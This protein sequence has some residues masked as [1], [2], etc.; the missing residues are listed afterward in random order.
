MARFATGSATLSARTRI[1]LQLSLL[2]DAAEDMAMNKANGLGGAA[3][4]LRSTAAHFV[5]HV[6]FRG[7]RMAACAPQGPL[8]DG[9]QIPQD[10]L[11]TAQRLPN[12]PETSGDALLAKAAASYGMP[13]PSGMTSSST[14]ALNPNLDQKLL[15]AQRGHLKFP[16]Q[17]CCLTLPAVV[18]CILCLDALPPWLATHR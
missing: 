1:S 17:R 5:E 16:P 14:H 8:A 15:A 7:G 13:P 10:K 2:A 9:V 6:D 4:H 18:G 3:Q 11:L 12:L